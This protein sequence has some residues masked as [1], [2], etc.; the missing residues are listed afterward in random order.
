V[1]PVAE[2]EVRALFNRQTDTLGRRITVSDIVQSA[3]VQGV[4]YVDVS[5]CTLQQ[6]VQEVI[7]LIPLDKTYFIALG[8]NDL[9][10]NTKYTERSVYYG[11]G[12]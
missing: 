6:G 1:L 12:A 9:Q 10:I 11:G 2:A 7:D 4:D 3:T 5:L 8:A